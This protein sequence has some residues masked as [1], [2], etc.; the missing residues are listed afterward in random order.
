M[1]VCL[2]SSEVAPFVGGG[3]AT[4]ILEMSRA[5]VGGGHEVHVLTSPFEGLAEGGAAALPGVRFHAV[6][7]QRGKAALPGAYYCHSSR[8]SMATLEALRPLH[9]AT[10]FD[11]IEFPEY[12][13]L[14]YWPIRAKRT[15]GDFEGAVLGVRLHTPHYV[16]REV[17]RTAILNTDLAHLE[18]MELWSAGEADVVIGASRAMLGRMERDLAAARVRPELPPMRLVR[19][20]L[21]MSEEFL[22]EARRARGRAAE[23]PEVLYFGR[24]QVC[25]GTHVFVDAAVRLLERGTRA[26]FR[27]I[28]GDTQTGPFG[29]S[30]REYLEGRVPE[31]LRGRVVFE[32][33]CERGRL[34]EAIGRA[35]ACVLPSLWD[36]YS[37]ACV[38][39][40]SAGACVVVSDGGSLPEIVED[41]VSGVVT[42]AGDA[43][44][45]ADGIARVLA[46]AGMRE[47]LGAGAR[48]RARLLS[49]PRGVVSE[50][51]RVVIGTRGTVRRARGAEAEGN[52]ITVIIPCY[53]VGQ[54]LP[55]T[56]D[57]LKGQTFKRF[58]LLIVD[59]GSTEPQTLALLERLK[60]EGYTVL[61]KRNGGLGSARNHGF[62]H[63]KTPWVVPIDG[64]DV[65][66]P[67]YVE[68]LYEAVTRDPSLACASCLF[69]SFSTRPGEAVSGYVPMAMDGNLLAFHNAAGPG[70]ASILSREI[71]LKVGGYDE[72]LTSFEDWDLWCTL[73]EHGYRGVAIPE[74]LLHYRLREGSLIRSEAL[75]RWHALKAYLIAKHPTMMTRPDVALRMQ[76]AET[77]EEKDRNAGLG[78]ELEALRAGAAANGTATC[79]SEELVRVEVK[80]AIAE[81]LR[82]RWADKVSRA[83]AAVGLKKAAKGAAGSVERIWT[84][85]GE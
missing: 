17:D 8:Y 65:A 60:G 81:N 83:L 41:G 23:E 63:A 78:R 26:R 6:D 68:R 29:R 27:L 11:Y 19:L 76:L 50:W 59:D 15:L 48:E 36:S 37:Y 39:A 46:D 35:E 22:G 13:G 80:R 79:V 69:E 21:A 61:H 25:K 82:Y 57:S 51:E 85:R 58:D 66:H 71:V 20:P 34:A 77:Y 18:H 52:P 56:L 43:E 84:G 74:F 38:E 10:P 9:A 3:L 14:G 70:A 5:L 72:W 24:L 53:N 28:G 2:V 4:Y 40:M 54:Y 47:R 49:E 67:R 32:P 64:D 62:R 45:L 55:E 7:L 33:A 44:S 42:R 75:H 16:C 31:G 1:R 73:V 12:L 30:M